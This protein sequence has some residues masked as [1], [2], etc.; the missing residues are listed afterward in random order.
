MKSR[1][2]AENRFFRHISGI[3]GQ[4]SLLI[5]N[6]ALSYFR[7]WHFASVCKIL[8]KNIKYSSRNSRNTVFRR[9]SAVPTIFRKF[10]I[11]NS[12][13]L[14]I[15]SCLMVGIVINNVFV[16]KNNEIQGKSLIKICKN[17][18][19][20]HFQSEKNFPEKLDL[21][22]FWALLIRIFVQKIRKNK[23]WNLEKMP[24]NRFFRHISSIFGRKWIFSRN[25]ALIH[26]GHYQLSFCSFVPKI[27]KK[28]MSQSREKLVTN[29]RT[30]ERTWVNYRTSR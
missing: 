10:R 15:E 28:I 13:L 19:F 2:N 11:Q 25:R 9:K 22:M 27:R 6:R 14:T 23:W 21:A 24:K 29:G 26:F 5:E 12:V 20:R 1:E 17:G 4:K 16:G 18:D 7:Y 3:F 8:W 30:N